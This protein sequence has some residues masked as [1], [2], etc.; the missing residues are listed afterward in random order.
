[1]TPV[2]RLWF[3]RLLIS[4][5]LLMNVQC[6]L[7]FIVA[8]A[9]YAPGFEL[10]G[11]VGEATVRGMGVLFLMWNVPY[12]VATL[13]PLKHRLS[14]YE[15]LAMQAMGVAGESWILWRLPAVHPA[16]T[17]TIARFVVFDALG[18]LALV[19]AALLA[20]YHFPRQV[21]PL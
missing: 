8:P 2:L 9:D 20:H 6:A 5:V 10:S 11:A 17:A 12:F 13:D 1:M 19:I 16:A 7:F 18:L 15:A 4:A 3:A 21:L 14:H